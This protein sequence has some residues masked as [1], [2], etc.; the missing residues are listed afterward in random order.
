MLAAACTVAHAQTYDSA[1]VFRFGAFG[2]Q[3]NTQF[4]VSRAGFSGSTSPSGFGGGA[5][6][7]FDYRFAP[8]WLAGVE[9]DLSVDN[10]KS[11]IDNNRG[12]NSDFLTTVRARLGFNPTRTWLLYGTAGMAALGTEYHSAPA[13]PSNNTPNKFSETR[14]GWTFGGGT[15]FDLDGYTIFAEYLHSTFDRWTFAAPDLNTM[16]T[17]DSSSDVFRLGVKFK[18]GYDYD[19][20]IYNSKARRY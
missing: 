12:F 9:A 2:Q 16:Y 4:D 11:K 13:A 6:I 17:V 5:A 19:H 20:D 7:G 8:Q 1:G 15:E 3:A 10:T 14:F 18:V